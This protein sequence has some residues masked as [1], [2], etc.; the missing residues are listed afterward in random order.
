MNALRHQAQVLGSASMDGLADHLERGGAYMR[1]TVP[2]GRDNK[3]AVEHQFGHYGADVVEEIIQRGRVIVYFDDLD[4]AMRYVMVFERKFSD[5]S[6]VVSAIEV[7]A[8]DFN[9]EWTPVVED[10]PMGPRAFRPATS[11]GLNVTLH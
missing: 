6:D 3:A 1:A 10:G 8:K 4:T 7:V 5:G 9:Y 11:K 2:F